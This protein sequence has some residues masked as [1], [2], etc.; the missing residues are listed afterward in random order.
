MRNPVIAASI[1]TLILFG[2]AASGLIASTRI[3]EHQN[4]AAHRYE[5]VALQQ[6]STSNKQSASSKQDKPAA[7]KEKR[8]SRKS[9]STH[10]DSY[11]TG[12]SNTKSRTDIARN[13][14]KK[15]KK[16]R[17]ELKEKKAHK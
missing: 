4:K 3:K 8:I 5:Q 12:S 17:M 9:G 7:V 15:H 10:N 6:K 16:T 1:A 11:M 13:H 14:T 2:A